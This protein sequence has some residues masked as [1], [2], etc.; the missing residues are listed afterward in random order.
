MAT[1]LTTKQIVTFFGMIKI[2]YATEYYRISDRLGELATK[3]TAMNYVAAQT[4]TLILDWFDTKVSVDAPLENELKEIIDQFID[5]EY[6][7]VV[8][9]GGGV[10]ATSGVN[11]NPVDEKNRLIERAQ[12]ICPF[13]RGFQVALMDIEHG[14]SMGIGI[15]A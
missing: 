10:G 11:Y 9:N 8:L 2:P 5:I 6:N 12:E 7:F 3:F 15:R 4:K 1:T 13:Y 14:R